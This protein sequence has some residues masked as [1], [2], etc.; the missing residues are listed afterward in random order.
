[1]RYLA[2]GHESQPDTVYILVILSTHPPK[3][4]GRLGEV[5]RCVGGATTTSGGDELGSRRDRQ[6][7]ERGGFSHAYPP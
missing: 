5:A 1:M 2:R 6:R 4:E 7:P 3:E